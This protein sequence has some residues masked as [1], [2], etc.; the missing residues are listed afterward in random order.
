MGG[1]NLLVF[2]VR[3]GAVSVE[4]FLR[5]RFGARY[6]GLQG[7]AAAMMILLSGCLWPGKDLRPLIGFLGAYLFMCLCVRIDALRRQARG[8]SEH[9]RYN[10]WPRLLRWSAANREQAIKLVVEPIFVA[11]I[12][13]LIFQ[14]N[15]PLGAYLLFAAAC[16]FLSGWIDAMWDRH[17]AMNLRD[18]IFEQ[19]QSRHLLRE[20]R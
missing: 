3:M 10:G 6:V 15:Q 11:L 20:F 12:A 13:T 2:V 19:Q 1:V 9:S 7:A 16:L 17:R 8:D 18:A 4:V 14:R 5:R